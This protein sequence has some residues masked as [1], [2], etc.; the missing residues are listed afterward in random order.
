M[1]LSLFE[2]M[3]F[4]NS[5]R[6]GADVFRFNKFKFAY[7][8]TPGEKGYTA[9]LLPATSPRTLISTTGTKP[10]KHFVTCHFPNAKHVCGVQ[11]ETKCLVK[12]IGRRDGAVKTN[13]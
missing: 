8:K 3:V 2:R 12:L 4:V 7:S 13:D 5:R 6:G 9:V 11:I 1:L 10:M